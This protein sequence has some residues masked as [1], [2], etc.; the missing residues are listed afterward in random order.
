MMHGRPT[1]TAVPTQVVWFLA[2]W[3]KQLCSG[4]WTKILNTLG[5]GF[6]TSSSSLY[7]LPLTSGS[8]VSSPSLTLMFGSGS[9][10]RPTSYPSDVLHS[11]TLIS[12]SFNLFAGAFFAVDDFLARGFRDC[13]CFFVFHT[14][15]A[16]GPMF[17]SGSHELSSVLYPVHLTK[18]S[19]WPSSFTRSSMIA[20]TSNSSWRSSSSSAS[21][22]C[23]FRFTCLRFRPILDA[24]QFCTVRATCRK[25][26]IR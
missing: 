4:S 16:A 1:R 22:S 24:C 8:H 13:R 11:A 26:A 19:L 3:T 9:D 15:M 5:F 2:C 7:S 20:S 12:P 14:F 6:V 10:I 21:S 25:D 17:S 23:S 18:N